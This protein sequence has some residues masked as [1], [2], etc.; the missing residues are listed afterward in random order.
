MGGSSSSKSVTDNSTNIS[1]ATTT[2]IGDIGISGG[3]AVELANVI[4]RGIAFNTAQVTD[5]TLFQAQEFLTG[6]A[7]Q[8]QIEASAKAKIS[9]TLILAGIVAA[10]GIIAL[11]RKAA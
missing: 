11:S 5:A 8:D 2:S 3:E 10:A 4:A 6:Q 1:T 7:Q 9:P